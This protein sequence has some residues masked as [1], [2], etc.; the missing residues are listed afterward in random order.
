MAF[1]HRYKTQPVNNAVVNAVV[2]P[3]VYVGSGNI[4]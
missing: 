4:W 3:S 1:R 2:N